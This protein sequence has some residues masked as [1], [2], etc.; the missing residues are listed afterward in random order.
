RIRRP[1]AGRGAFTIVVSKLMI[2]AAK[3]SVTKM[4]PLPRTATPRPFSSLVSPGLPVRARAPVWDVVARS[5]AAERGTCPAQPLRAAE[6]AEAPSTPLP[7]PA[8]RCF[9][10]HQGGSYPPPEAVDQEEQQA[11]HRQFHV[12]VSTGWP[13]CWT[14]STTGHAFV[15]FCLSGVPDGSPRERLR[16]ARPP[17]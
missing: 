8:G 14:S 12:H 3:H 2:S 13:Q 10:W 17:R 11:D 5:L 1:S 4:S 16:R 6:A 7:M 15:L 9:P